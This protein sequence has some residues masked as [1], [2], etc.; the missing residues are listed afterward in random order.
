MYF[1]EQNILLCAIDHGFSTIK[2]PHYIF[3]NGVEEIGTEATLEAKTMKYQNSYY[4][5][6]EGRLPLKDTKTE[7]EDYI[8]LTY[9]AI[10][11][12]AEYYHLSGVDGIRVVIAAGLPFTRFGEEKSEFSNYLKRGIVNFVYEGK[13]YNINILNVL[14]YPQCYA[15][16]ANILGKL[17]PNQLI[18]DIGSKT[19]D[20][21]RNKNYVPVERECITIPEALIH[22][23]TD[24]NKVVFRRKNRY[25]DESDI[26]SVMMTGKANLPNEITVIVREQLRIFAENVEAQLKEHGFDP[27]LTPIVYVGGGA[28]VMKQFGA[29]R[30]TNICYQEDVKANAIGYEYL[31]L[32]K[33]GRWLNE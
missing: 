33:T 27:E 24:V 14:L 17:A 32:Q 9:A 18:V 22:C 4:K 20:I 10:A 26:Q 31:A 19:I 5:I 11:K 1:K 8:L 13:T 15:A 12:E 6:G 29:I 23:M 25:L 2:T 7:D 28:I 3:D 30:G 16:V 21:I